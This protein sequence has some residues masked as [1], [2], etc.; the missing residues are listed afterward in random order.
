[1]AS[2]KRLVL[3][4]ICAIGCGDNAPPTCD[5]PP[6]PLP[7]SGDYLDPYELELPA[8]CVDAGL[9]ELYGRWFVRD[10]SQ[11]FEFEYPAFEGDCHTGF[12]RVGDR[13]DDH[14]DSDGYTKH[15]W[16]D[17]TR[18]FRRE[19]YRFGVVG[20]DTGSYVRA[21]VTCMLPDDRIA[22]TYVRS[23][24]FGSG[25]PNIDLAQAI[26]TRFGRKDAEANNLALVG[27]LGKSPQDLPV[28]GLN[29]VIDGT[30]AYVAGFTGLHVIDVADP[31]KPVHA[32]RLQGYFNDVKVVH[33]GDRTYAILAPIY[34]ERTS[35]V[36]V[37]TPSEPTLVSVIDEYSHSLFIQQRDG[38]TELYLANYENYVPK[39]DITN[40]LFASR[41]ANLRVPGDRSGVHDLFV[42]GDHVYANYTEAGFVAFDVSTGASNPLLLGRLATSY[43]HASWRGVAGGRQVVLH[44]DEGMTGTADGGAF[45]R[46]LDADTSSPSFLTELGRYQTRPEVGIHNIEMHGSRAYIAYYQ[47]GVRV[48]DLSD[49]TMPR[50][51]GHY[52]TWNPTT[53]LGSAF[54]GAAGIR[55]V[56]G[57][58]YV[59]DTERGL[60]ILRETE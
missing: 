44:G 33:A 57:I 45:M 1:M 9:R 27:E 47:D 43:S 58:I 34:N 50:E 59:A 20:G 18:L 35:V 37:T 10:S 54:E 49:P 21:S 30:H 12:A 28:A 51:V 56:N 48:V 42:E 16:S 24:R 26:G 32:G 60:V 11:K 38:I 36:D 23:F 5:V 22:V 8:D 31:A 55:L 15:S 25:D 7:A 52:N 13:E 39:Y 3:L 53:S 19:E 2:M 46:V 6:S 41:M 4:M 29:L 17:G 40:P 14:D